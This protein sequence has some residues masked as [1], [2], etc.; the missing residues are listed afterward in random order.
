MTDIPPLDICVDSY[1]P[2]QV[3]DPRRRPS[4]VNLRST[5]RNEL[6]L[7]NQKMWEERQ[8]LRVSFVNRSLEDWLREEIEHYAREWLQYANLRFVFGNFPDA[9]IRVT[10]FTKTY[11]S[12][13]GTDAMSVPSDQPTMFLGGPNGNLARVGD[14]AERRR[15]VLHEFG[16][17]LGCIHEQARP[18]SPIP[19]DED[20]VYAYYAQ[21]HGWDRAA[22]DANIFKRYAPDDLRASDTYDTTSI[23]QYAVDSALTRDGFSIPWNMELSDTDK[24]FIARAYP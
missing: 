8:T 11:S 16:H 15:I 1:P 23:M 20:K 18:N 21:H 6:A 17:A 4:P 24:E 13:V 12:K 7:A 2:G 9:E 22:V 3:F 19:W 14:A 10:I 5:S